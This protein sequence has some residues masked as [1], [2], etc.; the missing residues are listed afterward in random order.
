MRGLLLVGLLG[1]CAGDGEMN[2]VVPGGGGGHGS[3][4]D[5]SGDGSGSG[6]GSGSQINGRVCLT[7]DARKPTSCATTGADN[8]TVTLGSSTATTAAGGT[9]TIAQPTGTNLQWQVTGTDLM[10]SIASYSPTALIPAM[11]ISDYLD[12]ASNNAVVGQSGFGDVF[13]HVTGAHAVQV[14]A[15]VAPAS[16]YVTLYDGNAPTTWTQ[17]GTDALGMVWIPG[18]TAGAANVTLTPLGGTATV[19]NTIPIGDQTLTWVTVDLP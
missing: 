9:F 10:T 12:L 18:L 17:L 2:M 7:S 16:I 3:S 1:A 19:V 6:S 5:G 8:L 14:S 13:V 11:T 15:T 4:H